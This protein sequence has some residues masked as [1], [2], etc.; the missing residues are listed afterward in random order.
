V[1]RG[2]IGRRLGV[3]LLLEALHRMRDSGRARCEV[4]WVGPIRFYARTVGAT[5]GRAYVVHTRRGRPA[6]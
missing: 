3:P 6:P 1:R 2:A 4:A 5:V